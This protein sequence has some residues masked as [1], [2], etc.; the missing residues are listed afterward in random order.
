MSAILRK[1]NPTTRA[2]ADQG[3]NLRSATGQEC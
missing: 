2:T 3:R 1:W